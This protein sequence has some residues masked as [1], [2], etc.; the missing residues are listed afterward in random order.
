M[1]KKIEIYD[2]Q[3]I[4]DM[5]GSFERILKELDIIDIEREDVPRKKGVLIIEFIED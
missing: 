3:N 2:Y 4:Y 5:Q 1:K